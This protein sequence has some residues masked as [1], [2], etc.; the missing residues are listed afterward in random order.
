MQIQ[1]CASHYTVCICMHSQTGEQAVAVCTTWEQ[2]HTAYEA[3]W[4]LHCLL[5][6][7]LPF[8]PIA[9]SKPPSASQPVSISAIL[10]GLTPLHRQHRHNQIILL[11]H[12]AANQPRGWVNGRVQVG[13][14]KCKGSQ[15][16]QKDAVAA[17]FK[18]QIRASEWHH[19]HQS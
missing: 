9:P 19:T 4:I 16:G 2:Q 10:L 15:V 11:G 17:G 12:T 1:K 18:M 13:N 7:H 8:P 14:K 3:L 5:H 6:W